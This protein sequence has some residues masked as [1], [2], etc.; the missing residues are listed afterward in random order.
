MSYLYFPFLG[1]DVQ[2]GGETEVPL[3]YI[4]NKTPTPNSPNS[5]FHLLM[6]V[7]KKR[8]NDY[9]DIFLGRLSIFLVSTVP[10]WVVLRCL[11][12]QNILKRYVSYPRDHFKNSFFLYCREH[13]DV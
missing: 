3:P 5:S 9:L 8:V 4:H 1:R 12:L 10:L 2:K 7:H 6:Y 11:D 13:H